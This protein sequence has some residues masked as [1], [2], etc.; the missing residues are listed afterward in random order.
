LCKISIIRLVIEYIFIINLFRDININTICYR[1]GQ[2]LSY[3]DRH[4]SY[5]YILFEGVSPT[6][7]ACH[8][9]KSQR[10]ACYTPN[11]ILRLLKFL[12]RLHPLVQTTNQHLSLF[13]STHAISPNICFFFLKY[14]PLRLCLLIQNIPCNLHPITKHTLSFQIL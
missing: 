3:F 14:G 13:H 11:N 7:T 2:T 1:F 4:G 9:Q 8:T 5:N 10:I 12:G 6:I